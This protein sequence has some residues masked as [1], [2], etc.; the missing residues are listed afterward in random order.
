M[1]KEK[2]LEQIAKELSSLNRKMELLIASLSN[3][4]KEF[5]NEQKIPL[6][7]SHGEINNQ[8]TK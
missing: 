4:K 3:S 6:I 5:E 2:S 8:S 1:D 7:G